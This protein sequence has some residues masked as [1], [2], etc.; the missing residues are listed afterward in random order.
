MTSGYIPPKDE[1]G[2]DE[3]LVALGE[4]LNN[5]P[6]LAEMPE[7]EV[8]RRLDLDGRLAREP[9]PPLVAE[10]LRAIEAEGGDP[11]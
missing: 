4:A 2:L 10:A 9:S 8:A 7:E 11:A 5:N 3:I 6:R 1:P